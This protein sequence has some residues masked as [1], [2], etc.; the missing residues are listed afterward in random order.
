MQ[1]ILA[2]VVLAGTFTIYTGPALPDQ[3]IEAITD[4]GPILE[5]IV[6]CSRGTAII[7]YSKLEKLYCDPRLIC[8]A[9]RESVIERACGGP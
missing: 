6:R 5:M 2:A 9:S 3:Q 1:A 4:R 7:S 8:S